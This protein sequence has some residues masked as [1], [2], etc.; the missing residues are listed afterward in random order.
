MV[1]ILQILMSFG[2]S[3][4]LLSGSALAQGDKAASR[5]KTSAPA[6]SAAA[7]PAA[8]GSVLT[9]SAGL[10]GLQNV[11]AT[12][13]GKPIQRAD[14][15][16]AVTMIAGG[17]KPDAK[18][19]PQFQATALATLIHQR[20]MLD[21]LERNNSQATPAE[22]DA[23]LEQ[24]RKQLKEK[25]LTLEQALARTGQSL[26]MFRSQLGMQMSLDKFFAS[27][28]TPETVEEYFKKNAKQFD[29]TQLRVSHIL[30]RPHK[31]DDAA[32]WEELRAKAESIKKQIETGKLSFAEAAKQHSAGPSRREGGDLGWIRRD[33]PMVDDFN[34]AAYGLELNTV[35]DPIRTAFGIHL[36]TVTETKPGDK[37]FADV[38]PSVMRQY[39]LTEM[40]RIVTQELEAAKIQFAPGVPH[41]KPGTK[42]L[43][44]AGGRSGP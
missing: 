8:P 22:V 39:A 11:V 18:T 17:R 28:T 37:T 1:L 3:A 41:Y 29:G 14:V 40:E 9:P 13:N 23:Q 7:T 4:L 44:I 35:S 21:Y 20:L 36:I 25:N 16:R 26:A 5:I 31:P 12:V 27:Q 32:E 33:G 30:L 43:V 38:R 15:D 2:L 6:R 42:E 10:A 19:L 34:R 24:F